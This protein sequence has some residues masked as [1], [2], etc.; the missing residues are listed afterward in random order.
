MRGKKTLAAACA[1][2]AGWASGAVITDTTGYVTFTANDV[3]QT[4]SFAPGGVK[5]WSDGQDPH[6][7]AD[8][9][10]Q[11]NGRG[12]WFGRNDFNLRTKEGAGDMTFAG[13]SLTLD[14]G[15]LNLKHE[16]GRT[17]KANWIL[18]GCRIANGN[19]NAGYETN[20]RLDGP[21]EIR[22]TAD[23]PSWFT[24]SAAD[25]DR[26]ITV[27]SPLTGDATAVVGVRRTPTDGGDTAGKLMRVCFRG[28]NSAYKGRWRVIGSG[29]SD[30]CYI[31]DFLGSK[32]FG[33]HDPADR[34]PLVETANHAVIRGSEGV[35]FTDTNW[36]KAQGTL[37]LS[38]QN[39]KSLSGRR[40]NEGL[41]FTG[42]FRIVGDGTG[43]LLI[44]NTPSPVVFDNVGVADFSRINI[45][46]TLRVYPGY[47]NPDMPINI[48]SGGMLAD[49]SDGIGPTTLT[50]MLSPG[51]GAGDV[52]KMTLVSLDVEE[53]G[54]LIYSF[55]RDEQGE[56]ISDF[57]R[58][59]GNLT[60]RGTSRI[61]I[62]IDTLVS[63]STPLTFRLLTAAN[64]GTSLTADDFEVTMTSLY[65]AALL[66]GE[67]RVEDV[68]GEPVL[69]WVQNPVMVV[70]LKGQDGNAPTS[71]TSAGAWEDKLAPSPDK[72]YVLPSGAL[73]R[74]RTS[75]TF[76]GQSL[77]VLGGGDFAINGVSATVPDLRLFNDASLTV[78]NDGSANR[79][80][81]KMTVYAQK[82]S[83]AS[84]QAEAGNNATTRTLNLDAEIA[85][86]GDLRLRYYKTSN[87]DRNP[88]CYFLVNGDNRAFT[89]GIEL[90]QR[91][92]V[93][94][95]KDANALG[96]QA[97]EFRAD[98][99]RFTSNAVLRVSHSYA[100]D[101]PTMGIT[102]GVGTVGDAPRD[103]GTMQ[104]EAD[105]TLTVSVPVAGTTHWRKTGKGT[106][107]LDGTHTNPF[108]GMIN[109]KDGTVEVRNPDAL[110]NATIAFRSDSRM[111]LARAEPL[112]VKAPSALVSEEDGAPHHLNLSTIALETAPSTVRVAVPLMRF[113][114]TSLEE[115]TLDFNL[116]NLDW[117][118]LTRGGWIN[119]QL[120]LQA[121]GE[122]VLL[123]ATARRDTMT[124]LIR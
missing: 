49:E 53:G 52:G 84:L 73:L 23:N 77:S 66:S 104:V 69:T 3:G 6:A 29:K 25:G 44:R 85:G 80:L 96:G 12:D 30:T 41:Y 20:L 100:I 17:V 62:E 58:V 75:T 71:F 11:G 39:G 70:N 36:I 67:L 60:R 83:P 123:V 18:Y 119:K 113:P 110:A 102:M 61:P 14:D 90:F 88:C 22:G 5:H 76:A 78:R 79:L 10:V 47:N 24:A 1:V 46:N 13:D 98:R 43:E 108:S 120:A 93:T 111:K 101:D 57:I 94:D 45:L 34:L 64:L 48:A 122:D 40:D 9:L 55:N 16:N 81:G 105:Q 103:G 68:D 72:H 7:G 116:I 26:A 32:S 95:F 50:G 63:S 115:A 28:D 99:L 8:Y 21:M 82:G 59:T 65:Q 86:T 114:K 42:G 117:G 87:G 74:A 118:A 107:V 31:L 56:P 89:G 91:S 4:T 121:D 27:A 51:V 124:I 33:T 35:A 2:L 15:A 112:V 37:R 106:L 109:L 97:A 92:V 54:R 19:S 38:G